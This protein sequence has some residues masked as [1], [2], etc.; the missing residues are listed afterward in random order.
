MKNLTTAP[1]AL[2]LAILGAGAWGMAGCGDDDGGATSSPDAGSD[3]AIENDAAQSDA[4]PSGPT[5]KQPSRGSSIALSED[6]A[7]VVTL[8]RE[9]STVTVLSVE[10]AA[11]G[12]AAT[13]TKKAAL[14]VGAEPWQV[15]IGPDNDTAYVVVRKDQKLVKITGLKT[16]PTVA[17]SVPVGSEPTSVALAPSGKTAWVANWVDGTVMGVD[18]AQLAVTST[19][20]LNDALLKTGLVGTAVTT[21]R[22]ALAHPRSIAITNNGDAKDDDETMVVTEYFAQQEVPLAADGSNADV[23]KAGLVYRIKLGD[24]SVAT[25]RLKAIANIGFNDSNG[26][27]AGCFPNQLQAVALAG[28][29]AYVSSIC[30]SPKGPVGVVT[31]ATPPNPAN[32]KTTT[33]GVVSVVDLATGNEVQTATAS[34]HA[35]FDAL[36]TQKSVPDD[37]S[38]RYPATP[39]DIA[40]VPSLGVAYVVANASSAVFRVKYDLSADSAISEVGASTQNFIDLQPAAFSAP[41]KG[42][43]PTGIAVSNTGKRFAFVANDFSR[44][45]SVVDLN[46]QAVVADKVVAYTDQPAANS[47][48][49]KVHRGRHFF[50]TALGRWSLKGQGWTGCAACHTDGYTDNVTWFFARGPRQSTSLDGSFSKK[51]PAA[52]QRIFNWTG[53]FD[54][55]GDF[56]GNTRGVSGGVGAVVGTLSTPAATTDRIDLAAVQTGSASSPVVQNHNGLNGSVEQVLDPA[57]ALALITTNKLQDWNEIKAY[58]QSIRTPRAP[59]NLDAAKVAAGRNLFTGDG[60][61]QGC[62]GGDKWTL[63]KVF[64]TRSVTNNDALLTKAWA[65]PAGFPAALLPATSAQFMR[66][67]GTDAASFDQI[68]CVLRPVGTFNVADSFMGISEKRQNMA[69]T[70]QGDELNGKGYNPPSLFSVNIGAPYLHAG[71]AATLESLFSSTFNVHAQSLSAN[72]LA[73][74]DATVRATKVD[75][76]VQFLLSIDQDTATVALPS[77][78]ASGGSFCAAP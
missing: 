64:W 61:C 19:V 46:G 9:G 23:A 75:Q 38:R 47:T 68:Q 21:A 76:L 16:T 71:Q 3:S 40:F 57:N 8:D 62:H 14:S 25:T 48:A 30:A 55:V 18:T 7:T 2:G 5:L 17:G 77:V 24:K 66:S 53:I 35:R 50:N 39:A 59:T 54:E 11:D 49:E 60:S 70:A 65:P 52:D 44:N 41:Q 51:D 74:A 72:F 15:A 13:L 27:P 42:L 63:S 67:L 73:D 26:N 31:T 12:T 34:L 78:G 4:G 22:P 69:A 58:I 36:Y 1:I 43:D 45:V 33:H 20:D 37:G 10:Y 56:E 28:K 32:V 29:F 6:D